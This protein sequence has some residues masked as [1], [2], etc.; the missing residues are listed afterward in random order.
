MKYLFVGDVHNHLNIFKDVEKLDKQWNFDRIIFFGDYVDDWNTNNHHSLETLDKVFELKY[1][2]PNK[3]TF[4]LG[5][6]ELSYLGYKCSGHQ[7]ELEDIMEVKLKE[8]ID[9]FDLYTKVYT[10]DK[11]DFICTHAGL[12]NDFVENV[13]GG[14][15]WKQTLQLMNKDILHNL[16]LLSMCSFRRGGN[17]RCSSFLWA[18]RLEHY[19]I[20]EPI[21]PNQ[22]VGHSPV[23]NITYNNGIYFI[24]THSTYRDGS[25]YGDNSYLMWWEDEFKL[26]D[27]T[28]QIVE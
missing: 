2:N 18:D 17:D 23:R 6:H 7:Y 24:D 9:V 28:L 8:N 22:I 27:N 20:E 1:G 25:T 14:D 10:W 21:I 16:K 15:E 3:Y 13:L 12:T 26:I 4:L 19:E 5:N 11:G